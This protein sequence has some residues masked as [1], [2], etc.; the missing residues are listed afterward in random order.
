VKL[1][2]YG[3]RPSLQLPAKSIPTSPTSGDW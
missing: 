2:N 1:T 3:D